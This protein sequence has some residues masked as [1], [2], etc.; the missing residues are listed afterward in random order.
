MISNFCTAW[1]GAWFLLSLL[2]ISE[3]TALDN[4][5]PPAE[6]RKTATARQ[7][8]SARHVVDPDKQEQLF[9][10]PMIVEFPLSFF[11]T[12]NGQVRISRSTEDLAKF[13]CD[14]VSIEWLTVR[15]ELKQT[16]N[17]TPFDVSLR[18]WTKRGID[19]LT[20]VKV[21]L[22]DGEQILGSRSLLNLDTEEGKKLTS[23]TRV[24]GAT[25][26]VAAASDL[27]LRFTVS[28]ED[29]P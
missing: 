18:F 26:R 2:N 9:D 23:S 5:L 15:A 10:S 14:A 21:E 12:P 20:N 11:T 1:C 3:V 16:R 8:P 29:N 6:S 19:K 22:V 25:T 17:N 27:K 7:G 4:A 13:V 28:V 24:S